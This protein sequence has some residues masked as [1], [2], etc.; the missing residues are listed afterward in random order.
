MS[1][2]GHIQDG[3]VI[4][5]DPISLPDGTK[6]VV[7]PVDLP[8]GGFWRTLSLDDLARQQGV[9]PPKGDE[10]FLGGWPDSELN[11]GFESVLSQR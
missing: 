7:E 10:E 2:Q 5:D 8:A 11:D 4:L 6:V 1:Y 3:A 9:V